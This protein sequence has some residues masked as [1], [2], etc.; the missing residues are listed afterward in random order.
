MD[1]V[2]KKR[3]DFRQN[4]A[5]ALLSVS[6][7][8]LFS[9]TQLFQLGRSSYF[10]F[11]SVV[12]AQAESSETERSPLTAPVRLAVTASYGRYGSITAATGDESFLPLRRLLGDALGGA[13]AIASCGEEAFFQALSSTSVYYDFLHPLPLDTVAGLIDAPASVDGT[14]RSLA[15]AGEADG[16]SLY[17]WDGESRYSRCA[18]SISPAELEEAVALYEVGNALFAFDRA[19][20]DRTYGAVA[21]C[22]LFLEQVPSLPVLSAE[23]PP[24]GTDALLSALGFNPMTNSR[25]SESNGTEVI[26]DGSRSLRIHSGEALVYQDSGRAGL[27]IDAA[28]D[29]PTPREAATGCGA[30]L[31]SLLSAGGCTTPVYLRELRQEG[32]A[33]TL[34]FDYQFGGVPICFDRGG[35]A[36][37]IT[38]TGRTVTS[39]ELLPRQYTAGETASLLLP[40]RQAL[41]VASLHPGGE[42][43]IG[44]V[45]SGAAVVEAM[46]LSDLP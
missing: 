11:L 10:R 33:M 2:R 21:P 20:S 14:V 26:V 7:V 5:I 4:I 44:Y 34:R 37:E 45:D 17:L 6:A 30:L 16:V 23:V 36:A 9:R 15:V 46:W 27:L 25:Y 31:G 32:A 41:G 28:G 24:S 43:S 12:D 3:R 1:E 38:L 13:G 40:L 22:S 42:L 29:Q 18:V 39:L 8:F 35:S 19:A